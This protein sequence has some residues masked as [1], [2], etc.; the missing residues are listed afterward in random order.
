[1]KWKKSISLINQSLIIFKKGKLD[2]FTKFSIFIG[3]FLILF[4]STAYAAVLANISTI[5]KISGTTGSYQYYTLS[6][7]AGARDLEVYTS[8]SNGDANLYV[9]FNR[10]PTT[11]D[12]DYRSGSYTSNE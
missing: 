5:P 2:L 4:S 9:A 11:T 7:P 10:E 12:F 1:M 6:I 3:L 8:S